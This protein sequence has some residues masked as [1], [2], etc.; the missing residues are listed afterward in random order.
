MSRRLALMAEATDDSYAGEL[1]VQVSLNLVDNGATMFM[2]MI[3]N[4]KIL[5]RPY[6]VTAKCKIAMR[7]TLLTNRFDSVDLAILVCKRFLFGC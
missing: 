7:F 6:S 3:Y 2:C 1:P 5:P 4:R